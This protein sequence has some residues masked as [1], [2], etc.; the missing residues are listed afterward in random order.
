MRFLGKT[1]F[2]AWLVSTLAAVACG[3][4]AIV[5]PPKG[6]GGGTSTG[7][8]A[9]GTSTTTG[10]NTT[11]TGPCECTSNADCPEIDD[12]CYYFACQSCSCVQTPEPAGVLCGFG[13]CDGKENCVE[14]LKSTD[15]NG[16]ETCVDNYCIPSIEGV[17]K[18]VCGQLE[19]CAET[20]PECPQGC[21]EELVDCDGKQLNQV[22][23]CGSQL[24]AD[25]DI[26][27]WYSC[28]EA[29]SCISF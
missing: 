7:S 26:D 22:M 8:T 2:T 12:A 29:I 14:C 1:L 21:G 4:K 28:M 10:P 11:N 3:G 23:A 25:C 27:L 20:S 18:F 24:A 13:V 17:C 16:G 6:S 9:T 15:C 19:N 5:D